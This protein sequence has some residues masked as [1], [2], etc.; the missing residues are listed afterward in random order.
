MS[1][2]IYRDDDI[3]E[4][5]YVQY[6]T[7]GDLK[8]PT[9]DGTTGQVLSTDGSGN[10]SFSTNGT[11]DVIGPSSSTT[12][13]I[14]RYGDTTGKLIINSLVTIDNSGKVTAPSLVAGTLTYPTADGTS[15][16]VLSTNGSGVLSFVSRV[17][18]PGSSTTNA[19]ARFADT[20]G[21]SLVNSLVTIDGTGKITAPSIVAANLTYPTTDGTSDQVLS[22]NGSGILSF[23]SLPSLTNKLYGRNVTGQTTNVSSGDHL[24][25]NSVSFSAGTNISLDTTTSYT[26]TPN[27]NSIGRI[28]LIGGKTYYIESWVVQVSGTSIVVAVYNADSNT[29]IDGPT[30]GNINGCLA[31]FSPVTTT[32][33]EVQITSSLLVTNINRT[34]V[35]VIQLN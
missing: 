14:A 21:N 7:A 4:T 31:V 28:T 34:F 11:G 30:S 12:N 13:A 9:G 10:L 5:L 19:V 6:L 25:F 18:G 24:K 20:T 15:S 1:N 23:V 27:V 3:F 8:Y 29:F 16:Q 35:K 26:T 22:T 32:R 33:I 2:K 17:S